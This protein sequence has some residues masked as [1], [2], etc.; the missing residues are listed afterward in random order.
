MLEIECEGEKRQNGR[1]FTFLWTTV[2]VAHLRGGVLL[3][4]APTTGSKDALH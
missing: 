4:S 1:M 2:Q 3:C